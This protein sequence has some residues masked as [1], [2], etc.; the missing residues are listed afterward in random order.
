MVHWRVLILPF[1]VTL[2]T[3]LGDVKGNY[4]I[5]VFNFIAFSAKQEFPYCSISKFQTDIE[6]S[7]F[8]FLS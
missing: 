5:L 3:L 7:K 2:P 1:S 6:V 4:F 8:L